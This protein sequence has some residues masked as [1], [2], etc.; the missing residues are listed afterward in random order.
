MVLIQVHIQFYF[1]WTSFKLR[2]YYTF[3]S[4]QLF[5]LMRFLAVLVIFSTF[6]WS[7]NCPP[8]QRTLPQLHPLYPCFSVALIYSA[9]RK[10]VLWFII[11]SPCIWT[12][13]TLW[14]VQYRGFV[15]VS[16]GE[17]TVGGEW[18]GGEEPQLSV[19]CVFRPTW[20]I[21]K[22]FRVAEWE[23]RK[24]EY[25]DINSYTFQMKRQ[26][27]IQLQRSAVS[28]LFSSVTVSNNTDQITVFA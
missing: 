21:V 7:R 17:V 15:C 3:V 18:S 27:V 22:G 14:A 5:L 13:A 24:S 19:C 1:L 23:V 11:Y 16:H 26:N 25:I 20:A 10:N 12:N 2:L 9:Q 4:I 6:I 8:P 28:S